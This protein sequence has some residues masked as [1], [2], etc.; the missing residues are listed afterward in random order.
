MPE[1][2]FLLQL[3]RANCS[4]LFEDQAPIKV[5]T[6]VPY[7]I[8]VLSGTTGKILL[9]WDGTSGNDFAR[10]VTETEMRLARYLDSGGYKARAEGAANGSRLERLETALEEQKRRNEE[11]GEKLE[12][13]ELQRVEALEMENANLRREKEMWVL[14]LGKLRE[15][16]ASLFETPR[17][18][19]DYKTK[20]SIDVL[21]AQLR[22]KL[23][24]SVEPISYSNWESLEE[25]VRE[26]EAWMGDHTCSTA[27]DT[28]ET[29]SEV[30]A[31][32]DD[33]SCFAYGQ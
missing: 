13:L 24:N 4:I 27:D 32:G 16:V 2:V 28:S 5:A 17:K 20:D 7:R 19:E 26:L 30:G 8:V 3:L 6:I 14:G 33:T 31:G 22:E 15:A 23:Q 9:S 12:K 11:L 1:R 21:I 18:R 25:R 29:W 10:F